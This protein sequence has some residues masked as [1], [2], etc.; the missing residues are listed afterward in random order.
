MKKKNNL[1]EL[2][3]RTDQSTVEKGFE[4]LITTRTKKYLREKKIKQKI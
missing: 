2:A 4:N 3:V 1:L